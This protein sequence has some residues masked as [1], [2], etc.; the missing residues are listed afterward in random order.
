MMTFEEMKEYLLA[1][2]K[3]EREKMLKK[4][5]S[6]YSYIFML[7]NDMGLIDPVKEMGN[8]ETRTAV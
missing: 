3:E 5:G 7:C 8:D 1:E 4:Q 2:L 6:N